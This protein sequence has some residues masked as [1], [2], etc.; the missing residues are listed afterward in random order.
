MHIYSIGPFSVSVMTMLF[1]IIVFL[2]APKVKLNRLF[3]LLCMSVFVWAFG[4]AQMYNTKNNDDLSLFWAR[5]GYC[6][7]VFIPVFTW[8]YIKIF[9]GLKRRKLTSCFVY[10]I[11]ITF[12]FISRT[13]LFLNGMYTAYFWGPY[14]K[15]GPLYIYFALFFSWIFIR[16]VFLLYSDLRQK[17][18]ELLPIQVN[19]IKYLLVGFGI[20]STSII[21]YVQNY[22]FEIYPWGYLSAFGW[23]VCMG[24]ASFRY[25]LMDI[26]IA[27]TRAGIFTF[28]YILVL[29][30]P[31][32]VGFKVLGMGLWILPISIMAVFSSLAPF[33]YNYLRHR[34]EDV[35][36]RQQKRYQEA[37]YRLSST[38]TLVKD[39]DRLVRQ[40]V[41][42]VSKVVKVNF[43]CIYLLD[44]AQ[45]KLVQKSPYT[46][47][48]F[49]PDM[50]REILLSSAFV[51]FVT[52]KHRPVFAEELPADAGKEFRLKNGL[53]IPSFVKRKLLGFL[54]LGPKSTGA[55]YTQDDI[56][57]FEILANQAALAIENTEF[58]E[59]FQ[60]T[61]AQLFATER[62]ASM[63][64]M[65]GGMS[66]QINN[67]FHSI[68]LA[69]SNTIDSQNFINSDGCSAEIKEYLG[70]VKYA[71]GRIEENAKHGGK[72][73]NDFLNFSQPDRMKKEA[74]QFDL[75]EPLA[76]A[77]EM[78]RIKTAF[79]ADTIVQDIPSDLPQIE[80]DFVLLQD[81]FFNLLDNALDAVKN[82]SN[83]KAS[84][85]YKGVINVRMSS[86]D[87]R[88]TITIKDNG[89]GISEETKKKMFV[90]FFTTKATA[91]KGT[92]L[93]LF[94]IQKIIT[95]HQGEVFLNSEY[96]EGTEFIIHL[97]VRQRSES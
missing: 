75:R 69:T 60:K 6:G 92:G 65:A 51:E 3:C 15:A 68:M 43:A 70:Q 67:R 31:F 61:Q 58:L 96:G 18:K 48:G 53:I 2:M 39:L 55:M 79:P 5:F 71:L 59:E 82:K 94:V 63:G 78:V 36:L 64:A 90:P 56:H 30:I 97:P 12:F 54:L 62:M 45:N 20:A 44:P 80:G 27:L 83:Q 46:T 21:D 72:I 22:G 34:A 32:W 1:G 74:K 11:G 19:R 35:L 76:S 10:F 24:W 49:F 50:P 16:V 73:V 86:H 23:L 42:R 4:Y 8:H 52:G 87:S 88:I 37:L 7:V 91:S 9:L 95:A 89:T 29:G 93:G 66:H 26:N 85:G 57:V 47:L 40:I 81:V 38:M 28:V 77:I 84:S 25:N 17:K 13:P 33:I 14:P 41:W